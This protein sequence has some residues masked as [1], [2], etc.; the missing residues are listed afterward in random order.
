MIGARMNGVLGEIALR[1][2]DLTAS[3]NAPS[4]ADGIEIDAERTCGLEQAC[5]VSEFAPLAGGCEDDSMGA[6]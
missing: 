4:A 6:H 2:V 1:D 3:A 5:A